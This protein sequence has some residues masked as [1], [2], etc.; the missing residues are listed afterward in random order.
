MKFYR[1]SIFP[2]SKLVLACICNAFRLL[3]RVRGAGTPRGQ[4]CSMLV[5]EKHG[6]TYVGVPLTGSRTLLRALYLDNDYAATEIRCIPRE[7]LGRHGSSKNGVVFSFARNPWSRVVSCYN[8]QIMNCNTL[9][10]LYYASRYRGLRPLMGFREFVFWLLSEE[11]RDEIADPHW[12]AQ[13]HFLYDEHGEPLFDHL[14]RLESFEEDVS[15]FAKQM[16]MPKPDLKAVCTSEQMPLKPLHRGYR[17][18][19]DDTT[20]E[21]VHQ[22][23]SQDIEVLGYTF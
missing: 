12:L 4:Y 9:A 6:W 16:N 7:H 22:R 14:G 23:Y 19:Y 5:S 3:P 17:D 13:T 1:R 21:L 11:G 15:R 18:Y 20:R 10:K 2:N 8:K